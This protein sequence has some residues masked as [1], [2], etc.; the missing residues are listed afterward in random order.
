[1]SRTSCL[2]L[3]MTFWRRHCSGPYRNRRSLRHA[4]GVG[5]ACYGSHGQPSAPL[6]LPGKPDQ[7]A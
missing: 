6:W 7:E 4:R 1:L 3:L 5:T 2:V